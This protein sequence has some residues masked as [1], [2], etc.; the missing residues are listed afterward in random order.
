MPA[1][2]TADAAVER[3]R[4]NKRLAE[5]GLCSRREADEWVA[6]EIGRAH[7]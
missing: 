4:I 2:A 1:A 6:R 5:L 3:V 7:V